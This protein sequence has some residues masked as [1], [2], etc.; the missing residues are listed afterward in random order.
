MADQ[1]PNASPPREDLYRALPTGIEIRA[2]ADGG[3]PTLAGHFA[4]FN[5]WT[6]IN[7]MWEGNFL[8]RIAPG[9][10]TKTIKESQPSMRVLFNHGQD[11]QIGDKVLGPITALREEAEGPYYEVTLLDTSYNRDLV[12]GLEAGLYGASF[13]FKVLRE[14]MV[15]KPKPSAANP[16]G[17]PERTIKEAGVS[18]FGP[19]TFPAYPGATAGLRSLTDEFLLARFLEDP[20]RL[21]AMLEAHRAGKFAAKVEAR[22]D[23]PSI[24]LL[25]QMHD[26]GTEFIETETD[27]DDAADRDAMTQILASIEALVEAEAAEPPGRSATA[28]GESDADHTDHLALPRRD[29]EHDHFWF[30]P[31]PSTKGAT[32]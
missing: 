19:V 15:D 8:E 18:E 16:R 30:V 3:M 5:Q 7:S 12:P 21:Q 26:L 17:L 13:R 24:S 23:M 20:E 27:P 32:R 9:A 22:A 1:T 28:P 11:P 14:E 29:S 10:F 31:N 4:V 25:T 2:A 6:E